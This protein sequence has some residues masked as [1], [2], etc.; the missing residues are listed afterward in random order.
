MTQNS[1]D[2]IHRFIFDKCNL[3]G[4]IITLSNTFIEATAHQQTLPPVAK[5]LLGEFLAAT[6]LLAEI[7][8]F[9]GT[10][11]LQ[12]RG[13]GAIPLLMAEATHERNLRGIVRVSE[14]TAIEELA[15]ATF[16]QLLGEGILTLTVDPIKGKR[17]Q[18]IVPL[19][20]ENIGECLTHYFN[21]SEQLPTK[22]W[23]CSDTNRA[24]GLLLQ[25][26]PAQGDTDDPL[27]H[28]NTAEQLAAT[29][30]DDELLNLDHATLLM[31]L[32]NEFEV[33]LFEPDSVHF[34]CSCSRE[35]SSNALT[36]LG[37]EDAHALLAEQGTIDMDCQFCG[38]HYRFGSPDLEA[39]FGPQSGPLH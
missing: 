3:R 18:G 19:Q 35:R 29:L 28:W 30:T 2:Q 16:A 37:S 13:S 14:N 24:A 4:E 39:L 7:F 11:T 25:A 1:D 31:R 10:L 21:Q 15:S 5:V 9:E 20:G 8:K 17:Y 22:L 36:A 34:A 6:S 23:L 32:F 26:L 33:R 38:A 12:V 27:E